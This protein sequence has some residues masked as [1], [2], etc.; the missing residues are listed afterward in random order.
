M[1]EN[2]SYYMVVAGST[3]RNLVNSVSEAMLDGWVP[4]GG[5]TVDR[6]TSYEIVPI[7][8]A[9]PEEYTD[10]KFFVANAPGMPTYYQTMVRS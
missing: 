2:N 10:A 9:R 4:V 5:M 6:P 1:S 8:W 7:R 3:V